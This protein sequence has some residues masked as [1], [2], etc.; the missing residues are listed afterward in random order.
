VDN[1]PQGGHDEAPHVD[2]SF[3]NPDCQGAA[4]TPN[5]PRIDC[6]AQGHCKE[7]YPLGEPV[8]VTRVNETPPEIRALN[9]AVQEKVSQATGGQSV[10]Q[11]YKLVNVLWD[12]AA[13]PPQSEPGPGAGVPI[14]YGSFKSAGQKPVANTTMETYVQ[15]QQCTGC[16]ASATI[17]GNDSLAADFSFLF[18]EADSSA[19]DEDDGM[20]R[21]R[22][23]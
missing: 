2:Y 22:E 12:Q 14:S 17:S 11:H 16:H 3:N 1:V 8:P 21:G 23:Q 5:Q 4:C 7:L 19:D 6:D 9:R 18:I 10:F 13:L 20:I 15:D